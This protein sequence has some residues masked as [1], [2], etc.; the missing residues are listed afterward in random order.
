MIRKD[1]FDQVGLYDSR[2]I[3]E[4]FYMNLK[5]ASKYPIGFIDQYLGYY[6]IPAGKGKLDRYQYLT[7]SHRKILENY[8]D[9]PKFLTAVKITSLR[10]FD[11][12]SGFKGYKKIALQNMLRS[13]GVCYH[14]RFMIAIIKLLF[15]HKNP[16]EI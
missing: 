13:L 4:D 14:K 11:T 15:F 3:T 7:E 9:H 1:V 12:Y 2:Y 8:R 10:N 6:R 16:N 5:I